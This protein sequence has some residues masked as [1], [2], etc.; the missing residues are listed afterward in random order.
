M[1]EIYPLDIAAEISYAREWW[2]SRNPAFADF[3]DMGGD[4]TSFVSQC[5][6]AG[7][8]VM[9][10]TRDTGWYYRS[11]GDRAAAW[12]GVEYFY[13][14]ITTNRGAGPF[15]RNIPVSDAGAGDVI[16]LCAGNGCYHSLF[17]IGRENGEP[18]VAA[19]SFDAIDR[20][21]SSY[22]YFSARAL[23]IRYARRYVSRRRP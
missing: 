18:L 21:L 1:L 6:M 3:S 19:H 23:N 14:F 13:R 15:G 10:F 20:P 5:L 8:A 11:L 7:G 16:Q 12:T 22:D 17:V 9:N 4:C 2:D